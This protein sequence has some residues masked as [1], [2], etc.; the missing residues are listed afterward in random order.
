M[1][2]S[3]TWF[4]GIC[5]GFVII[6]S[7]AESSDANLFH[8][9]EALLYHLD[10]TT[11]LNEKNVNESKITGFSIRCEISV[12]TIWKSDNENVLKFEVCM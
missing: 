10:T 5:Y 1:Y 12:E 4:I 9:T 6:S 2:L 3:Y 7:A 11:L 8:S